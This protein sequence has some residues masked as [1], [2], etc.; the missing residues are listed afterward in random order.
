MMLLPTH[1]FS[2]SRARATP[3][4]PAGDGERCDEEGRRHGGG[5]GGGE[6]TTVMRMSAGGHS[7]T[8]PP[9][10]ETTN[11]PRKRRDIKSDRRRRRRKPALIDGWVDWWSSVPE[12]RRLQA[13]A[14]TGSRASRGDG[15]GAVS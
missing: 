8:Q 6:M 4:C 13:V 15:E 9:D 11:A 5:V 14:L 7:L 2:I 12:R 10:D 1:Y 3:M